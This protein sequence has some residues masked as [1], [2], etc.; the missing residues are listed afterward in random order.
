MHGLEAEYFGKI[1]FTYLDVD[2]PANE[3]FKQQFKFVYQPQLILLDG[4]GQI[5]Q[6]W[7]GPIPRDE[8]VTAFDQIL[9][10]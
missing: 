2:D 7:I 8:F 1:D 4:N 3:T 5:V 9:S 6:Q 10:Q